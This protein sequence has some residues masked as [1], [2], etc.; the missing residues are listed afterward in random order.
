MLRCACLSAPW[1][2]Q[3]IPGVPGKGLDEAV[4]AHLS[5]QWIKKPP[6]RDAHTELGLFHLPADAKNW[7]LN[8]FCSETVPIM[9]LMGTQWTC[10]PL[11]KSSQPKQ[12]DGAFIFFKVMVF[13][14]FCSVICCCCCGGG[15]L[16]LGGFAQTRFLV[17]FQY[18]W[19]MEHWGPMMERI[20][21]PY[22]LPPLLFFF[23][24]NLTLPAVL[25]L[26]SF[27]SL[28]PTYLPILAFFCSLLPPSASPFNP[29]VPPSP[30]LLLLPSIL[31]LL[32]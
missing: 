16:K 21:V 26:P 24:S 28:S 22:F 8:Y 10:K 7:K 23:A 1:V 32:G 15:L 30:A 31:Y 5:P 13:H 3:E 19:E 25:P 2:F 14:T 12:L 17:L 18:K 9:C 4:L 29:F 20:Q 27:A 6:S 11:G